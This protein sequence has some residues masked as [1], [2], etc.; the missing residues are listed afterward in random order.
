M[1]T[2]EL[3]DTRYSTHTSQLDTSS[4]VFQHGRITVSYKVC[5]TQLSSVF[6]RGIALNLVLCQRAVLFTLRNVR[7][8]FLSPDDHRAV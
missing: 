7:R 8:T 6:G 5:Y 3:T 2:S 1:N 4:A